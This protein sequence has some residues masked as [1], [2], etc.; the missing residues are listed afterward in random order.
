MKSS[1]TPSGYLSLGQIFLG[2]LLLTV[3]L[4]TRFASASACVEEQA[5]KTVE[6][7]A[8][9]VR[10]TFADNVRDIFGAPLLDC[11]KG[12]TFS[13][14]ADFHVQTTAKERYDV[15]LY[16]AID[17]DPNNDGAKSGACSANIIRDHHLDPALPNI[18]KLGAGS[19]ADLDGDACRDINS[20]HGWR[21]IGGKVVTLRVDNVLCHDSDAD[22][23]LNLPNCTSWS[24]DAGG[25]CTSPK[26]AAPRSPSN[27]GCDIA[28][29]VPISVAPTTIQVTET[30]RRQS[31]AEHRRDRVFLSETSGSNESQ[32]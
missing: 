23:K 27:C 26:N 11:V 12:R 20:A 7:S 3:F 6:C 32:P 4:A 5:D 19:A 24:P 14:I 15:G 1:N 25:A 31:F 10:V 2:L 17:G 21:H 29:N 28:F 30:D 9:D 13:F 16:F 18:V 8:K 22:G